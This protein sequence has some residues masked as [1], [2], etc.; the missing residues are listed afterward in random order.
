MKLKP[1]LFAAGLLT[2]VAVQ[3]ERIELTDGGTI[4]GTVISMQN[5]SYQIQ[6]SSMGIVTVPQ[7]K[8]RSI[9]SGSAAPSPNLQQQRD[10]AGASAV[11]SM[12]STMVNDPGIMSSILMLQQDPD[13]QA[14]LQDPEVMRAVQNF[15]LQTLQNHPKIKKLMN[16]REIK[17]ITDKVN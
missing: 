4:N 9:S 13:M 6:T 15:D 16:K 7:S 2:S 10:Q 11:Q 14:I 1:L 12:Q 17:A 5:G 3:A 8:I